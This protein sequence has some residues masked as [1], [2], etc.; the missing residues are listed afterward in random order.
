MRI[1]GLWV[2]FA[3]E[4]G[5]PVLQSKSYPK[6]CKLFR[7][8]IYKPR[9]AW[10]WGRNTEPVCPSVALSC[11]YSPPVVLTVLHFSAVKKNS[12]KSGPTSEVLGVMPS[13]ALGYGRAHFVSLLITM[14]L[15]IL[16]CLGLK[17]KGFC[18]GVR[19][20]LPPGQWQ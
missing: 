2:L 19:H 10:S 17:W 12:W 15:L 9:G 16:A 7:L 5:G 14:K 6:V 13:R 11:A 20:A 3:T 4:N 18:R 8:R 1:H